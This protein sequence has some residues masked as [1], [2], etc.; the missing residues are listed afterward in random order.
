MEYVGREAHFYAI[1]NG[2]QGCES[3]ANQAWWAF[4]VLDLQADG[5]LNGG[6]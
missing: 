2:Y 5:Y 3:L 4:Q 6:Q 1:T